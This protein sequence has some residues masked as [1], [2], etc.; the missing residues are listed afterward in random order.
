M[1]GAMPEVFY[2][3][4][5]RDAQGSVPV[6]TKLGFYKAAIPA[7]IID[8]FEPSDVQMRYLSSHG[9]TFTFGAG[10]SFTNR[11]DAGKLYDL[12][13][14]GTYTVVLSHPDPVTW[15]E[16]KSNPVT[17]TVLP[18][19]PA[20]TQPNTDAPPTAPFSVTIDQVSNKPPLPVGL[21]VITKNISIHRILIRREEHAE[22]TAMLGPVFRAEAHDARGIAPRETELARAAGNS[23]ETT[24]DPS[25]M[26][27]AR[28]AGDLVSI[29]PGE[30]WWDTIKVN[31]LYDLHKPGT[32]T[33]QVRRWD[34]ETKTWVKSN[35]I[36]LTVTP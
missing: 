22:D 10:S 15:K 8:K 4:E 6:L 3:V 11:V 9:S 12:T 31:D 14:A 34:D 1:A 28:A 21:H 18:A 20:E 35:T 16:V 33:L 23:G 29:G 27:S 26:A 24:P 7:H 5:A 36:T 30:D 25:F 13:K 17:V 19:P 2:R 32:Y